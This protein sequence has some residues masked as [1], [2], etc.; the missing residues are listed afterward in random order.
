ML[1]QGTGD[2]TE[3]KQ[4]FLEL[5]GLDIYR[6]GLNAQ[7]AWDNLPNREEVDERDF[8]GW[9]SSYSFKAECWLGHV[10][11]LDKDPNSALG[12]PAWGTLILYLI[13][14]ST[15]AGGGFA[16]LYDYNARDWKAKEDKP[17]SKSVRYFK[18]VACEH[19]FVEKNIGNCLHRYTCKKCGYSYDVDS[20]G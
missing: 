12:N 7:Y 5:F 15:M 16:V 9:R 1:I 4:R 11:V 18:W 6:A 2:H 13:D 14:H 8:W 19:D 3:L 10:K 20:S 17:G